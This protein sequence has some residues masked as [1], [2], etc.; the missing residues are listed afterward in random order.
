LISSS[1][2]SP[3]CSS[4]S[5]L[6]SLGVWR[7]EPKP[8]PFS[9]YIG[10]FHVVGDILCCCSCRRYAGPETCVGE[11]RD[12][13]GLLVDEDM[14]PRPSR[15]VADLVRVSGSGDD[16]RDGRGVLARGPPMARVSR[17][18]TRGP[19]TVDH[20]LRRDGGFP[21]A[22]RGSFV[23]VVWIC[24]CPAGASR[25]GYSTGLILARQIAIEAHTQRRDPSV[26]PSRSSNKLW[27]KV[28]GHLGRL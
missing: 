23:E 19:T 16:R 27:E 12:T 17:V 14:S 8:A 6:S 25:P 20:R 7:F 2:L 1:S 15:L 21:W 28:P 24:D 13:G 3:A 26:V 9:R 11:A 10:V 18:T 5:P 4:Q 22:R